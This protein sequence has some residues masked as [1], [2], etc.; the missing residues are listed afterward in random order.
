VTLNFIKEP[1]GQ[2]MLYVGFG[3]ITAGVLWIRKLLDLQI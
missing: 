3:F 1:E 2:H